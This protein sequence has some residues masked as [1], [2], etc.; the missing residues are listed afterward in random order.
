M[1][2]EKDNLKIFALGGLN[3]IGKNCY[4]IEKNNEIIVV[5]AGVKFLSGNYNLANAIIPNFDYLKNNKDKVKGV[6]VTHGHEDHIGAIPYLLEVVPGT[7][8]Y[9][10]E[11]SLAILRQKMKNSTKFQSL[12][13]SDET[14]VRTAEFKFQFFRVT[15]SI[16]GSFGVIVE[17]LTGN[18]RIALTGDFKFD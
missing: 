9:G 11:F 17:T 3:E 13:F 2:K 6:F 5:D 12:S 4:V 15:H 7:P 10:S 1:V 8:I 14:V 16:P 18:V